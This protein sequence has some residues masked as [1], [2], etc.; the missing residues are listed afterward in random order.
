MQCI[1]QYHVGQF[2]CAYTS[3]MVLPCLVKKSTSQLMVSIAALC[4]TLSLLYKPLGYRVPRDARWPPDPG[5]IFGDASHEPVYRDGR[6]W[7]LWSGFTYRVLSR[8]SS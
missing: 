5:I 2:L 8:R 3:T 6:E 4:A 7:G 1:L